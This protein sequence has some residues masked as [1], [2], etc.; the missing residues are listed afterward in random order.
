MTNCESPAP[1]TSTPEAGVSLALAQARAQ[2]IQ[3]VHYDLFFN[4]PDQL[5]ASIPCQYGG[6]V[7]LSESCQ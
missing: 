2:E 4:V 1:E 5:D 3:D 7:H 6:E